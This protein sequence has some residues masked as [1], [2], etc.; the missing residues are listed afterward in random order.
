[1][2]IEE[3]S[4]PIHYRIA[5]LKDIDSILRIHL[6]C[7]TPETN[8]LMLF[9]PGF[10]RAT[11]RWLITSPLAF[12]LV[13]ERNGLVIGFESATDRPFRRSLFL[14]NLT[15][16]VIAVLH[17]P[18]LVFQKELFLRALIE[19]LQK[20]GPRDPDSTV[21]AQLVLM[22]VHPD[23]REGFEVAS[24]LLKQV[25]AHGR[26][27]GWK[28]VIA[29]AYK[30]NITILFLYKIHGFKANPYRTTN[31]LACVEYRLN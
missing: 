18:W 3:A 24:G 10:L 22:G 19:S 4:N 15:P 11:Y 16:L 1:M 26:S 21:P 12:T 5:V 29:G 8:A 6:L 2:L 17:R 28:R 9:G 13:A 7:F 20:K 23:H 25:L 14:N 31:T 30:A 27:R